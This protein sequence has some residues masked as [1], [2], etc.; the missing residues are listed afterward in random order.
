MRKKPV[1]K[2]LYAI[3]P[4][5]S[6]TDELLR[7]VLLAL[8]GGASVLQYRNKIANA[9]LRKYQA[10]ALRQ[11]TSEFDCTYLVNDDAQLAAQVNADGVHLGGE[12]GSLAAVRELLGESKIIGMSCYN[13]LT[14]AQQAAKQGADYIAFGAFFPSQ[15]K[16]DA[17]KAEVKMLQAA[18]NELSLPIV[19]IGG[20]TRQNGALLI[21]AG[22]DALAVISALWNAAD[23]RVSAQEF[24]T[25]FSRA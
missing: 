11:L 15:V 13:R 6:N 22:A 14:L 9:E 18:R 10:L 24:S 8:L 3:T 17:V 25:L 12:D 23:I 2:G 7:K 19:A 16:P 5:E 1:I 20:I 4:D 21:E